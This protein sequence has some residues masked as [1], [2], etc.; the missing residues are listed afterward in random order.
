MYRERGKRYM[1]EKLIQLRSVYSIYTHITIG[2]YMC[3][4]HT[5]ERNLSKLKYVPRKKV[6]NA[7][8]HT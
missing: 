6:R 1:N 8:I 5:S 2:M 3:S 4:E 7:R